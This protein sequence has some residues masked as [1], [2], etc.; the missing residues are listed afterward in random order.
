ME[1][2]RLPEK[3]VRWLEGRGIT[4][5]TAQ[6][7]H[8]YYDKGRIVIPI[9][10]RDGEIAFV[11]TRRDPEL[12]DDAGPKYTYEKG[13]RATLYVPPFFD[14]GINPIFICEGELDCLRLASI[15]AIAVSS[16]GGAGTFK[17]EWADFFEGRETYICYDNDEAGIK[18]SFKLQQLIPHAKIMWL[19]RFDGKDVTDFIQQKSVV[20]F[21]RAVDRAERYVI[22][23]DLEGLPKSKNEIVKKRREFQAAIDE[24]MELKK[25]KLSLRDN[26]IEPLLI[27][28]DIL[29]RRF[30]QYVAWEQTY[31]KRGKDEQDFSDVVEAKRVPIS[32]F[33]RFNHQGFALCVWHDDT[34]PSMKYNG[35]ASNHPNTVKCF[36]CGMMG[37][38]IDVIIQMQK[39]TFKEAVRFLLNQ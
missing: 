5:E 35:A 12:G 13:S 38:V 33:I 37:D 2:T 11:K 1:T 3:I 36:S 31:K 10:N 21:M 32:M 17:P 26:Y 14:N 25:K 18:G 30:N 15:G 27:L 7:A 29:M 34:H 6:Q 24:V 22:P 23:S 8:L 9:F 19:G 39:F 28:K 20:E 16:T 4:S